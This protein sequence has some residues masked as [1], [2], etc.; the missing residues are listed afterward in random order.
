MV[1]K[2]GIHATEFRARTLEL[3]PGPVVEFVRF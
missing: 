2:A 1:L 3:A